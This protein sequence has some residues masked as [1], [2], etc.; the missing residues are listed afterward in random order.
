VKEEERRHVE[1]EGFFRERRLGKFLA[2]G[3]CVYVTLRLLRGG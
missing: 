2:E 3:R 1:K